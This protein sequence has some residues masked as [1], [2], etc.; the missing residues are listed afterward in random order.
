MYGREEYMFANLQAPL[1]FGAHYF[2]CSSTIKIIFDAADNSIFLSSS[3][4]LHCPPSKTKFVV[5]LLLH[6]WLKVTVTDISF[7]LG[8]FPVGVLFSPHLSAQRQP[9]PLVAGSFL[10]WWMCLGAP[11]LCGLVPS[12]CKNL[13]HIYVGSTRD[14]RCILSILSLEKW[15]EDDLW[16]W[17]R[18]WVLVYSCHSCSEQHALAI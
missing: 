8:R 5:A 2:S 11:L 9:L 16:R 3:R 12:S 6:V 1:D 13:L 4:I 14:E 17:D 7:I 10:L 18:N 15:V